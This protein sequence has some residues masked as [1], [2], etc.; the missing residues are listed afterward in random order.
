MVEDYRTPGRF[1]TSGASGHGAEKQKGGFRL[2]SKAAVFTGGGNSP[3]PIKSYWAFQPVKRPS[4]TRI[5]SG[6][7]AR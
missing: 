2:D 6:G 1:A 3:T 5:W 4:V 7:I